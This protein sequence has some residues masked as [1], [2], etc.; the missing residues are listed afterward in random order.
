LQ[1]GLPITAPLFCHPDGRMIETSEVR[2]MVKRV[3]EAA[4]RDPRRF[5][6]HSLRIGGATAALAME[7]PPQT[8]RLLGRWSSDIYTI[9]CRMSVQTALAAGTAIASAEVESLE[10]GFHDEHL[11]ILG[12]E[13]A[14]MREMLPVSVGDDVGVAEDPD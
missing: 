13:M 3:M 4:G 12:P 6:A 14:E 11:E 7:V 1:V 8:I 5:G 2:D 9:Y 10:Q